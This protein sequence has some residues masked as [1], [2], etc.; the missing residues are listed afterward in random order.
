M[1]LPV[2]STLALIV[3]IPLLAAAGAQPKV[4]GARGWA[5][6]CGLTPWPQA[7]PMT[8]PRD[9]GGPFGGFGYIPEGSSLRHTLGLTGQI[10]A[11]YSNMRNPLPPTPQNAQ[12]GAGVYDADCAS[13]HGVTGLADAPVSRKLNPPPAQLAWILRIPPARRDAFM[14]WSI[15]E[16]GVHLKT[17]MPAYKGKLT[18]EQ[19]WAVIGY[20]EARLPS[21]KAAPR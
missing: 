3:A 11:P 8:P 4:E 19:M 15:A 6:C 12:V 9:T 20:I 21:P 7:G 2:A 14:Y 16:G 10:P 5:G 18:D 17:D 13:C 1:R